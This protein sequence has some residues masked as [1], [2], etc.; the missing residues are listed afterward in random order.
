M[1]NTT[2]LIRKGQL[3][4]AASEKKILQEVV[5]DPFQGQMFVS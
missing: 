2:V 3:L 5:V 1:E 4:A